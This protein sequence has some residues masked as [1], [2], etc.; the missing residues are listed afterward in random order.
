MGQ[1]KKYRFFKLPLAALAFV[2][3]LISGP[4]ERSNVDGVSDSDSELAYEMPDF[5]E[6]KDFL[7][8]DAFAS[9]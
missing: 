6:L 2:I 5:Q 3:G 7:I 1:I 8:N 9:S 4:G